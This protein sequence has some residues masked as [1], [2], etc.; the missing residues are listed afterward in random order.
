MKLYGLNIRKKGRFY[1][2]KNI[3]QAAVEKRKE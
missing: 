3:I 1:E 2:D